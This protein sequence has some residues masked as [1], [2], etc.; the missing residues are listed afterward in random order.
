M[1]YRELT[2]WSPFR[3]KAVDPRRRIAEIQA[4]KDEIYR[5][6]ADKRDVRELEALAREQSELA[7]QMKLAEKKIA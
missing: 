5:M 7:V 4:R 3:K 6:P 1:R 2:E